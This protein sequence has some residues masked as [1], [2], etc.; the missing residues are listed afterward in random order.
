MN[1][2]FA[3]AVLNNT[4]FNKFQKLS[5]ICDNGGGDCQIYDAADEVTSSSTFLSYDLYT[6]TLG[7]IGSFPQEAY[8]FFI[9]SGEEYS[10]LSSCEGDEV[11]TYCCNVSS[12]LSPLITSPLVYK[13]YQT[14]HLCLLASAITG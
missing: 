12:L 1:L 10:C 5:P 13:C 3:C 7:M 11:T 9:S 14:F 8:R 4:Q 6:S 2:H